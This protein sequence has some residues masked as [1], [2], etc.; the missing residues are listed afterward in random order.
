[1]FNEGLLHVLNT[2]IEGKGEHPS[3]EDVQEEIVKNLKKHHISITAI[4]QIYSSGEKVAKAPLLP[5]PEILPP[6][7]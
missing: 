7:K 6:R 3:L 2:G 1:M 4:P 5:N